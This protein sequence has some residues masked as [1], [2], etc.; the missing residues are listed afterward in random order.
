MNTVVTKQPTENYAVHPKKF[1]LWVM[2]VAM[3]MLFAAFT[4]A[5]IVRRAEGNWDIFPLPMQFM[6]SVVIA[7]LGSI[8]MQWSYY[9]AK[10]DE[11]GQ[12]KIGLVITLALGIVFCVSQYLGWAEMTQNGFTLTGDNAP[13]KEYINQY[14]VTHVG[15]QNPASSFV[16]I[17]SA[18][19]VLHV[20]G[21]IIF[22]LVMTVQSFKLN[23]HKKNLLSISMCKTYWHFVGLL[24]IYLYLFLFLNR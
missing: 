6:Y 10:R 1:S 7:I 24:W 14:G 23:I 12:V 18:T 3:I 8:A 9:A 19:H 13:S 17:I 2:I 21:G 22:L 20:L 15:S 16:Y 4:S 5:Y 11:L